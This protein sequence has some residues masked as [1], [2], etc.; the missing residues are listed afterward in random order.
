M[1]KGDKLTQNPANSADY[2]SVSICFQDEDINFLF[3]ELLE[4]RGVKTKILADAASLVHETKII[5]EPIFFPMISP[6]V[7]KKCLIV[8]NKDALLGLDA[9]CLSRPLTEEKIEAA[10]QL[11]IDA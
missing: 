11:L 4:V 5:T 6:E 1:N 8:G 10:L 2:A 9:I 3:S 7:Q